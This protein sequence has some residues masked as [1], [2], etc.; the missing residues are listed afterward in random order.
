MQNSYQSQEMSYIDKGK[1]KDKTSQGQNPGRIGK[2]QE[3]RIDQD[4][5]QGYHP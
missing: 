3:T 4:Q 5:Q 2:A 1:G